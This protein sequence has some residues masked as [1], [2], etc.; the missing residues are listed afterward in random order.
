MSD[1]YKIRPA[2]PEDIDLLAGDYLALWDSYGVPREHHRPD[3]GNIVR[4]FL[5]EATE[6]FE[7]G[8]FIC[9]HEGKP[10]A[11]ACCQV[12]RSPYPEILQEPHRKI[13]YVWSVYINEKHQKRGLGAAL[14]R[15]CLDHLQ[16]IGCTS[17]V[18]HSSDAGRR[19]YQKLGF[20]ATEELSISWKD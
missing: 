13:G 5:I 4:T 6:V 16:S 18:L 8:A 19:L 12:R 9:E 1:A 10:V 11:S 2:E 7:L 20:T 17:V 15:C 3:A 14:M